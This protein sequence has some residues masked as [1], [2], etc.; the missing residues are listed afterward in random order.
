MPQ[1]SLYIDKETLEKM[2]AQARKNHTSLSRWVGNSLKH[3][4]KGD[5]PEGFF[6]LFG[7]V[8]DDTF[9]RPE[10]LSFGTD[11]RREVV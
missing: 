6:G 5:Y 2:E 11:S 4:I 10:H 7:S 9:G 8:K 1:V 3:L